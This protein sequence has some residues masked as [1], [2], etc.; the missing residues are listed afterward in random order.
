MLL[1]RRGGRINFSRSSDRSRSLRWTTV[2]PSWQAGLAKSLGSSAHGPRVLI[3]ANYLSTIFI[4]FLYTQ[5][6]GV[7]PNRHLPHPLSLS[8]P[9]LSLSFLWR[10]K[11]TPFFQRWRVWQNYVSV[12]FPPSLPSI[13]PSRGRLQAENLGITQNSLFDMFFV[14]VCVCVCA[15]ACARTGVS[16]YIYGSM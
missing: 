3:S 11:M 14:G 7:S 4:V 6:S 12:S 10:L 16:V 13:P 9:L 8:V 15:S 2:L 1:P 5:Y